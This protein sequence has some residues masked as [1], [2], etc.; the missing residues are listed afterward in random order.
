M[1]TTMTWL[2]GVPSGHREDGGKQVREW[3]HQRGCGK[4]KRDTTVH[5]VAIMRGAAGTAQPLL[6]APLSC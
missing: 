6:L 3:R 2:P 1:L 5:T 4:P